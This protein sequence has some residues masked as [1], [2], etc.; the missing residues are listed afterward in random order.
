M[1]HPHTVT[2]HTLW[3]HPSSLHALTHFTITHLTYLTYFRYL[4]LH[5]DN[6][7]EASGDEYSQML[8]HDNAP[9]HALHFPRRVAQVSEKRGND[10]GDMRFFRIGCVSS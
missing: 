3:R 4:G 5:Y 9:T 2:P 8:A 6:V 10:W 7:S 1:R